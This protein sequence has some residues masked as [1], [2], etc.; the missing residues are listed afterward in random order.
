MHSLTYQR[1]VFEGELASEIPV[2]KSSLGGT[3]LVGRMSVG[4]FW[5]WCWFH[6][7]TEVT[8]GN[9]NGLLLPISATDQGESLNI[10]SYRV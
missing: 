8:S 2:V 3:R 5:C 6:G 9:K 7:T 4:V 10:L 1:S